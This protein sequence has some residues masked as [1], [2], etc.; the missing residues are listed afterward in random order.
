MDD[1]GILGLV[2]LLRTAGLSVP[3]GNLITFTEAVAIIGD[4]LRSLYWCGRATLTHS[5]IDIELYDRVFRHWILGTEL[6]LT[7]AVMR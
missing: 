7:E 5:P 4:D 3:V 1:D 2:E 6:G